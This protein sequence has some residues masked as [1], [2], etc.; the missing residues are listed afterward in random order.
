MDNTDTQIPP[1]TTTPRHNWR[2]LI[3]GVVIIILV[4]A[5][6]TFAWLWWQAK[7]EA[8]NLSREKTS[9]QNALDAME[10]EQNNAN[11]S[12][13]STTPCTPT[14]SQ[15]LKDKI[16]A[17]LTAKNYSSIQSDMSAAVNVIFAASEKGGDVTPAQAVLDLAYLTS[18]TSP[19]DFNLPAS[20]L[21]NYK[22]GFYTTYFGTNTYAGK[23]ANSYIVSFDFD[24][25]AK[26]KTI[27][28]A[29]Q[30]DLVLP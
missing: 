9:L 27:F 6:T 15:A 29:S 8:A 17:A 2:A 21:A 23:S 28:V 25:C 3:F 13:K 18:A 24:E 30:E 1:V 16:K 14:I 7:H 4:I 26:I 12:G 11:S 5:A 10:T 19:W 22:A 20:T